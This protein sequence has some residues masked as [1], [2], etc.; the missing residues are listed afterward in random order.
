VLRAHQP[1]PRPRLPTED[2]HVDGY[3]TGT[4]VDPWTFINA[5]TTCNRAPVGALD[6]ATCTGISGW[7]QDP[8][9]PTRSISAHVSIGGPAGTAGVRSF[10]V[11]ADRS[12]ADLCATYGCAHGFSLPVPA[13]FFDGRERQVYAYGIDASNGHNPLLA[14]APKTLKCTP[15]QLPPTSR[16]VQRA[17]SAAAFT[18]WKFDSADVAA[19]TDAD[20]DALPEGSAL[21]PVPTL[22]QEQGRD[23]VSVFED[24]VLRPIAATSVF[25]ANRFQTSAIARQT[26]GSLETALRAATARWR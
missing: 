8:D 25:A 20:L 11:Q 17:V 12:R 18:A 9:A 16:L 23:E 3:W 24:G 5:R 13:S 19:L 21:P 4:N 26:P 15:D 22:V 2:G 6:A 1:A 14:G 7:A 10:A